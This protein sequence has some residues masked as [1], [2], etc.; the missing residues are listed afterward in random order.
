[1]PAKFS[2]EKAILEIEEIIEEIESESLDIDELSD[3]IKRV[4]GLIKSCKTKLSETRE[5]V[6][7]LL[8]ELEKEE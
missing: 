1:M 6:D 5:D 2:Y 7:K 8:N 3:K 4:S